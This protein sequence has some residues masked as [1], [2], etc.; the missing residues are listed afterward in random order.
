MR[1]T[2]PKLLH[3]IL[4]DRVADSADDLAVRDRNGSL[5]YR[6]LDRR[7]LRLAASLRNRGVGLETP[8]GVCV[9]RSVDLVT[10]FFG[11]LRAGGTYVPLDPANPIDRLDWMIKDAGLT[12][13]VTDTEHRDLLSRSVD[14]LSVDQDLAGP[15]PAWG[16]ILGQPDDSLAYIIYT[17][18]STGRPKGVM[19]SHRNAL[20]LVSAQRESGLVPTGSNILGFAPIGF[21]ASI[22]EILLAVGHGAP[23]EYVDSI[24]DLAAVENC[25]A[26]LVPSVLELLDPSSMSFSH[27]VSVGERLDAALAERWSRT[28]AISNA[29]GPAE[30]TVWA[31]LSER[32]TNFDEEPGIGGARSGSTVYLVDGSGRLVTP[33]D[34]GELCIGGNGVSRGYLGQPGLTASRFQPDPWGPAG[35]RMYRTGDLARQRPDGTYE[36][37]GRIDDQVKIGGRRVELGEIECALRTLQGVEDARVVLGKTQEGGRRLVAAVKAGNFVGTDEQITRS[38]RSRLPEHMI[39][40]SIFRV[41]SFPLTVNGKLDSAKLLAQMPAPEMERGFDHPAK[42]LVAALWA[43]TLGVPHVGPDDNFFSLGGHSLSASRLIARIR[44]SLQVSIPVRTLFQTPVLRAFLTDVVEP[45]VQ[46]SRSPEDDRTYWRHLLGDLRDVSDIPMVWRAPDSSF[47]DLSRGEFAVPFDL[48][49]AAR[50]LA[51][52]ELVTPFM[53]Y[54]AAF[55]VALCQQMMVPETVI[56]VSSGVRQAGERAPNILLVRVASPD[57]AVA[58]A[59]ALVRSGIV[60]AYRHQ[61]FPR[62]IAGDSANDS[63]R[64]VPGFMISMNEPGLEHEPARCAFHLELTE[65]I[66]GISGAISVVP[67]FSDRCEKLRDFHDTF[68]AVLRRMREQ[69]S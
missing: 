13:V 61:D 2:E 44:S 19:V 65:G 43:S 45:A 5:T 50:D 64:V 25:V 41:D 57:A 30:A 14:N 26:T 69:R 37:R 20:G 56:G 68:L 58:D 24:D 27:V 32:L 10:A 60:E 28:F 51:R 22:W 6:E 47:A 66:G 67:Q 9:T 7:S 49:E 63:G 33:G 46:E 55:G 52:R 31:T 53:V 29:Y 62:E 23:L 35:S 3:G 54:V 39:P 42:S 11:V 40:T 12:L 1:S 36:F 18:G 21:D 59:V 38:L 16:S 4:E 17:S 48:V 8:V 34:I 15:E